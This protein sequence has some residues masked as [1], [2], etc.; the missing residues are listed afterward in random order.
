MSE[1]WDE[2]CDV[3]VVGSG[4]GGLTASYF[5]GQHQLDTVLIEKT[6]L[7]GGTTAY[8]GAGMWLPGNEVLLRSGVEDSIDLGREYMQATVGDV[9]PAELQETYLRTGPELVALLEQVPGMELM[10]YVFPDYYTAPG[11]FPKGRSICPVPLP[12]DEI[13]DELVDMIRPKPDTDRMG[14]PRARDTL[15]GG[16]SLVG[17]FLRVL[18]KMPNVSLRRNA[19]LE[20]LVAEGDAVLGAV[21]RQDGQVKRI[22]ARRGIVL[23]AGGFERNGE[24]R[25]RY[26]APVGGDWSMGSPQNTGDAI[27]AGM[28]IG[29][30][31]DLLAE[32]W[33]APGLL[34]P[35]GSGAFLHKFVA[36]IVVDQ[37]GERFMNESLPYDQAGRAIL[38]HHA[39]GGPNIPSFLVWD[40]RMGDTFP[41][42]SQPL[43][44]SRA[45]MMDAGAWFSADTLDDLAAQLSI[46]ADSL[47]ATVERFNK[48]V[49]AGTDDDFHRGEASFD[50]FFGEGSDGPNPNLVAIESPP[51]NAVRIVPSDLGTKGGLKTDVH[52]RVLD[53]DGAPLVGLYAAG[54][55]M[56]SVM[57]KVY[58]GPGSP[59]GSSMVFGYLAV[60]DIVGE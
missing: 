43:A 15:I 39:A 11:F 30:D 24:F 4:A 33:W 40:G 12:G 19:A 23:A 55:T 5:A 17:R 36:G 50:A 28:A 13:D 16:Q 3:L 58:P 42:M 18:T 6:D 29:A 8:S 10:Y 44:P 49:V 37:N 1:R 34:L 25:G 47:R 35:D 22:R 27:Q 32:S 57:G 31:T 59:V 9:T 56:A 26:Q 7:F 38:A 48:F 14:R 45:E 53:E 20:E 54:N 46:P 41:A 52:A 21:V 2:E 51:Y 60:K